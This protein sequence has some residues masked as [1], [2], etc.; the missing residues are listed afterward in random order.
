MTAP[1]T[2]TGK[3]TTPKPR[4]GGP[5]LAPSQLR[6]A[7]APPALRYL[8]ERVT[9]EI[10]LRILDGTYRPGDIIP[11]E[12]AFCA[13]LGVSRT[14]LREAIKFLFSKGLVTPRV[15]VGTIVNPRRQWN[16]FDPTVLEWLLA[17]GDIGPFL[18]KLWALRKAVEPAAA[19]LAARHAGFEDFEALHRSFE[20]MVAAAD[21]LDAWVAADLR[22]H[23]AIYAATGNEFFWPVG[24]LLEPAFAAGLRVTGS[25]QHQQQCIP[26]HR[27]VRD[28]ILARDPAWAHRAVVEL[29][30]TSEADLWQALGSAANAG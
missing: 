14:A 20:A 8:N 7:T 21:D 27:A 11:S 30:R 23:Q 24:L 18:I 13:Q 2:L 15:K 12:V 1:R 4:R 28:A 19:A 3:T 17:V 29:M 5:A 26:E 6:L 25:A 9:R 10:G 22:F 16:F